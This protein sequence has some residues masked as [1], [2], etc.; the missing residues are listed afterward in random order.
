MTGFP[1][2]PRAPRAS[3]LYGK[4]VIVLWSLVSFGSKFYGRSY[5]WVTGAK[6]I[7]ADAGASECAPNRGTLVMQG[8][9][10]VCVEGDNRPASLGPLPRHTHRCSH[11]RL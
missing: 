5:P 3:L 9:F 10:F 6:L 7:D 1:R 8:S 4:H 2:V 11:E